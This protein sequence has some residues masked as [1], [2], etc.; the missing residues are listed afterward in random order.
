MWKDYFFDLL[1]A[2]GY[3]FSLLQSA[4]KFTIIKDFWGQN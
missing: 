4:E 1:Y 2:V 3:R